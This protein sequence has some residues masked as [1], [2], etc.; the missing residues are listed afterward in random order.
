MSIYNFISKY[1]YY[2]VSYQFSKN[3]GQSG[4]GSI[5]YAS[6]KYRDINWLRNYINDKNN[7]ESI[8]LNIIKINRKEYEAYVNGK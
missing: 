2:Y 7:C 4:F 5:A 8:I 6:T 1:K 3:N